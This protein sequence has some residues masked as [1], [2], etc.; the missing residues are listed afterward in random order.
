MVQSIRLG[1]KRS[2]G[3][4]WVLRDLEFGWK[5]IWRIKQKCKEIYLYVANRYHDS[6]AKY[7]SHNIQYNKMKLAALKSGETKEKMTFSL[8]FGTIK[9]I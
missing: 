7:K 9:L 5:W 1:L 3:L 8:G 6:E 4:A 2:R